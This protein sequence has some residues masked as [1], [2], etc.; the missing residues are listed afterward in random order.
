[1][2]VYQWAA[3]ASLMCSVAGAQAQVAP[4]TPANVSAATGMPIGPTTAADRGKWFVVSTVGPVSLLGAGPL[5]AAWGTMLN[6]PESY[7]RTWEGFGKRYGVRLTG[8]AVSN[9]TE[10]ALGALWDEDPRYYA[11]PNRNFKGRVGHVFKMT[12]MARRSDGSLM[13]AYGR[14]VAT[15]GNNILTNAWRPNDENDLNS[16]LSRTA[17][18]FLGRLG[19]NAFAEFWPTVKKKLFKK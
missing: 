14:Y 10:A 11:S 9:A 3:V 6:S 16:A 7:G 2:T 12:F 5:S 13:P 17:Y 1:M 15:V 18:G 19:S 8:V 4:G